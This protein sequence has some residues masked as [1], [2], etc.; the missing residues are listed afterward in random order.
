MRRPVFL[1]LAL[2]CAAV[3][4]FGADYGL[5]FHHTPELD[6]RGKDVDYGYSGGIGP[7]VSFLVGE[8][9]DVYL[10]GSFMV[11]YWQDTWEYRPELTRSLITWRASPSLTVSGGR[12]RFNDLNRVLAGGL[13]DGAAGTVVLGN[14]RLSLGAYYTGLLFK[15]TADVV[16]TAEDGEEY[17]R[18]L[19][20]TDFA[21]TC[22]A[23]R[24]LLAAAAWELPSLGGGPHGLFFQALAQFDLNGREEKVDTQYVS[25]QFLFSPDPVFEVVLGGIAGFSETSRD[26]DL[27]FGVLVDG[28]WT[29]PTPIGDLVSFGL[30]W[31]SGRINPVIGPLRPVTTLSQ[32]NVLSAELPGIT[33]IRAGYTVWLG[34]QFFVNFDG[35]YFLRN[36]TK[37]YEDAELA[38]KALGGEL[39]GAFTWAPVADISVVFGGGVFFPGTGNAFAAGEPVRWK[40]AA[41]LLFSF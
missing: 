16:M 2:C 20:Y 39:Y 4:A 25:F 10:S 33:L 37:T 1:G 12:F 26:A 22:F 21:G 36:D 28:S 35:R 13:F 11:R 34:E 29:P 14:T 9:I 17:N 23:S 6:A 31:G 5:I 41:S 18:E 15:G 24:R 8:N 3:T 32:G 27:G 40:S 7:W 19:D 30:H 38:G